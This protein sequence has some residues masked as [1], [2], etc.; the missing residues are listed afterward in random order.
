LEEMEALFPPPCPQE[1][2]RRPLSL[3]SPYFYLA[4]KRALYKGG[5]TLIK[6]RDAWFLGPLIKYLIGKN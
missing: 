2:A 1:E 5:Y 4:P 3:Y 6:K